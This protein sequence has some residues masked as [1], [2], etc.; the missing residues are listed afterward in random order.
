MPME[1]TTAH[2]FQVS[3]CGSSVAVNS[4]ISNFSLSASQA[5]MLLPFRNTHALQSFEAFVA[6]RKTPCIT[7]CRMQAD[8]FES[9]LRIYNPKTGIL[10]KTQG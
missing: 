3:S 8:A 9:P 2:C 7:Q 5:P 10:A 6:L 4:V 1:T